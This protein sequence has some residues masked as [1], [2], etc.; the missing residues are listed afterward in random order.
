MN[1][2]KFLAYTPWPGSYFFTEVSA[3]TRGI[4][5]EKR[6]KKL[7]VKITDAELVRRDLEEG[8]SPGKRS[9]LEFVIKKVIPEGKKE[10][11]Y[12]TFMN[13]A[14]QKPERTQRKSL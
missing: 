14:S 6:R 1:Y 4:N 10:V 12:R 7:R 3:E 8:Q 13:V 11:D 5:A 2:R 9:R